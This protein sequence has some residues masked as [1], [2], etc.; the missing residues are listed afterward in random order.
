MKTRIDRKSFSN[1]VALCLT[2][3]TLLNSCNDESSSI[4]IETEI[5]ELT[6]YA[7]EVLRSQDVLP[8]KFNKHLAIYHYT[9]KDSTLTGEIWY[10]NDSIVKQEGKTNFQIPLQFEISDRL[11]EEVDG[12]K[13][14]ETFNENICEVGGNS[15]WNKYYFTYD[16]LKRPI[17]VE[18]YKAWWYEGLYDEEKEVELERPDKPE[19]FQARTTT[20]RYQN[21]SIQE[22]V[23]SHEYDFTENVL[24]IFDDQNRLVLEIY[25]SN[26]QKKKYFYTYS[27]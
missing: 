13:E 10:L 9:N 2:F 6:E 7:S 3:S 20:Y 22:I 4:T 24:K 19:Y 23:T 21:N 1:Y 16:S 11:I 8:L 14:R 18:H 25:Q 15:A 12:K 5:P 17:R 27:D 26:D